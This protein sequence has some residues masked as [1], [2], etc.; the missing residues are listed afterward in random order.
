[1][2]N[3]KGYFSN[4]FF[5]RDFLSSLINFITFLLLLHVLR[6]EQSIFLYNDLLRL[7]FD[8][9][10][11]KDSLFKISFLA[12]SVM[13]LMYML[14]IVTNRAFLIARNYGKKLNIALFNER[15]DYHT[16]SKSDID[17]LYKNVFI[18]YPDLRVSQTT[19]TKEKIE[20]LLF[21]SREF[22]P[23]GYQHVARDYFLIVTY[24]QA[25][26]YSTI[27]L[28]INL[29]LA[30]NEYSHSNLLILSFSLLL[31]SFFISSASNLSRQ[32]LRHEYAQILSSVKIISI[33]EENEKQIERV[34]Y[35]NK[36]Y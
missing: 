25:T 11:G 36:R 5:A 12:L 21:L 1:M 18:G 3:E 34:I 6:P 15:Y 27:L 16:P 23:G 7:D 14:G 13:S 4:Y 8:S 20:R 32:A 22:N 29:Y 30:L 31:L 2:I 35:K 17:S 10:A 24:R 28:L 26:V 33:K 9:V 19:T